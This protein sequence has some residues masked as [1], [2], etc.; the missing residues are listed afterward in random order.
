MAFEESQLS[1]DGF[2]SSLYKNYN[3]PDIDS[4]SIDDSSDSVLGGSSTSSI[5]NTIE[6]IPESSIANNSLDFTKIIE[7]KSQ[8]F[9]EG[10]D[11]FIIKKD[12]SAKFND[13]VVRG[14]IAS[15]SL[16]TG[17]IDMGNGVDENGIIN[18]EHTDGMGDSALQVD[19]TD[20]GYSQDGLILGIDDAQHK[21]KFYISSGGNHLAFNGQDIETQGT[22]IA[23]TILKVAIYTV[24]ALPVPQTSVGYNSPTS[25]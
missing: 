3:L 12:G 22:L 7:L 16:I 19:K 5:G 15:G 1:Q 21:P 24:A 6:T 11:G 18:M 25:I 13:V 14:T 4:L 9:K 20:W 8:D 23:S 10:S 17:D 2:N